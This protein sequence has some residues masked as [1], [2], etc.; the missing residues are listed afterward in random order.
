MVSDLDII[1]FGIVEI[2]G[3]AQLSF[4]RLVGTSQSKCCLGSGFIVDGT[5]TSYGLDVIDSFQFQYIDS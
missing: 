3:V 2:K 4:R 5:L 1:N